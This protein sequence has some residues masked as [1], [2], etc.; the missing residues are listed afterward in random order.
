[1]KKNQTKKV[2]NKKNNTS[3]SFIEN[4]SICYLL[5]GIIVVLYLLIYKQVLNFDLVDWD[6]YGYIKTNPDIQ[7]LGNI[8]KFFSLFYMGNY[9]PLTILSWAI[10]YNWWQLNGHGY[11]LTNLMLHAFN[12]VL[13]FI[14]IK[15]LLNKNDISLFVSLLFAIH[16]MHAESIAWISERKDLLYSFFLLIALIN[17]IDFSNSK[18]NMSY[19]LTILFFTFSLLSKSAAVIFPLLLL[20]IDY[21]KNTSFSLKNN[22]LK[23]PFFILSVVF[24]IIAL[25]SQHT[26][27]DYNFAPSFPWYER[28]FI[29]SGGITF[30]LISLFYPFRQ[31]PLHPY[32]IHAFGTLPVYFYF[33]FIS[34]LALIFLIYIFKKQRRFIVFC[35][36]FF[37]INLLLVIQLIPVGKAI[38]AERYTYLSY[39]GLY[40]LIAYFILNLNKKYKRYL[41]FISGIWILMLAITTFNRLP[42][43]EN[44]DSLFSDIIKKYPKEESAYYNRGLVKFNIGD[45][46]GAFDD[47]SKSI[48]LKHDN[49]VAYY[50][51]SLIYLNRQDYKNVLA[52]LDSALKF[53]PDHLD[54]H[55]NR[56]IARAM[57]KDYDNSIKD[58]N[59]VLNK[60]P[61]DQTALL[62]RGFTFL[63][64]NKPEEACNDFNAAYRL[65]NSKAKEMIETQCK[66]SH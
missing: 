6:D 3:K 21:F 10:D 1:M 63:N 31:S 42:I 40:I 53:M 34:I 52:D 56:G 57:F 30:Y 29:A 45:M 2:Q 11:H 58:F 37:L 19:F 13:V 16:P 5:L 28:I 36:G 65:G 12:I 20:L 18:K 41:F 24:G 35:V 47:Y 14:F 39:L 46:N 61:N 43:W 26:A 66:K 32:P 64:M 44:S 50:N 49:A 8:N 55:K 33:S 7:H 62:N 54:A 60:I 17:Y 59:Y 51:R 15:K 38:V 48:L 4:N 22:L 23:I 27:M 25:K 9:H